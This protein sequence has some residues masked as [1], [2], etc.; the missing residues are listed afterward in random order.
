[1]LFSFSGIWEVL[2]NTSTYLLFECLFTQ[3]HP[4]QPDCFLC[5]KIRI[6]TERPSCRHP[7]RCSSPLSF[8]DT[9][10][11]FAMDGLK[12][13]IL[14]PQPSQ[15]FGFSAPSGISFVEQCCFRN[16]FLS[17]KL[18]IPKCTEAFLLLLSSQSTQS[19]IGI[20][21]EASFM[22][23]LRMKSVMDTIRMVEIILF[24][25]V[26]HMCVCGGTCMCTGAY[27]PVYTHEWRPEDNLR[28]CT[29]SETGLA[30]TNEATVPG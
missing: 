18:S 25:C 15:L 24:Y 14:M 30:L 20:L 6:L 22:C 13:S 23:F 28:S 3:S 21:S 26:L 7:P 5:G 17:M 4:G 19:I 1:M 9:A 11:I 2:Y 27:A 16:L 12:L 29:S 8:W 10:L